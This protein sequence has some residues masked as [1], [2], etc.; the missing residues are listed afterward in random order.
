VRD[1]QSPKKTV[2]SA[3]VD[4]ARKVLED[5]E[6]KFKLT[7]ELGN[8]AIREPVDVA[9]ALQEVARKVLKFERREA[10]WKTAGARILDENG[11]S[12]GE[13]S[14]KRSRVK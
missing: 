3:S 7:I 2:F 1:V 10:A 6:M 12:V 14:V 9:Y 4:D 11:N 8:E 13:W 5:T